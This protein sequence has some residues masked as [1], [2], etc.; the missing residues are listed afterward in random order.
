MHIFQKALEGAQDGIKIL[1]NLRY[2]DDTAIIADNLE[3]LHFTNER[4][5]LPLEINISKTKV[6]VFY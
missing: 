1:K 2:A 6:V 4:N 3:R 5:A